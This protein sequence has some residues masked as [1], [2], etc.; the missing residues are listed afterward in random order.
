MVFGLPYRLSELVG[1]LVAVSLAG[2]EQGGAHTPAAGPAAPSIPAKVLEVAPQRV[3]IVL[4][5]VGQVQGSKEVEVRA[6]VSGILLKRLYNEGDFVREGSSLFQIDPVPY[7]IALAQTNAQIAQERARQE[8][9]GREAV[10]LN[11]LAEEKAISQKEFDDAISAQKMSSATLQA[12]EANLRQAELN[13]SYTLVTA[14]VS[15]IAG[16]IARSEGSLV[17]AGQ[18][19]SLLTTMNQVHPIWV[20]FSLSESDIAK[21]PDRSPERIKAAEVR[22]ILPDGSLYPIKGRLNFTATQIDPRLATKELRAEFGNPQVQLL[23]GQFVRVRVVAGERDN[24]F[25]VPQT[26]VIQTEKTFLVFTLDRENKAAARPVQVGS[27]VGSDWMILSGLDAGDRII[28][29]N[30][31]KV[32]PGAVVNPQAAAEGKAA[33]APAAK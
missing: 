10:R 2:C 32:R 22:L 9:T 6:R 17:T 12:A 15:G 28:L 24:V 29:D 14:P 27:W 33:A 1:L 7:Q 25:L 20:R 5:A 8:Q 19:S 16:R 11:A 13:L 3:P 18:E 30:L 4:E 21:V 26:A 23:P 31:L